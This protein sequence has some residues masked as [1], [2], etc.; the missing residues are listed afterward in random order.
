MDDLLKYIPRER[1]G[2]VVLWDPSDPDWVL[3]LNLL[4]APTFRERLRKFANV[5]SILASLFENGW[6]GASDRNAFNIGYGMLCKEQ[7]PTFAHFLKAL[8]SKDYREELTPYID[9]ANVEQFFKQFDD[10]WSKTQRNTS[11]APLTNKADFFS[12]PF[13]REVVGYHSGVDLGAIQN[14]RPIFLCR[15]SEGKLGKD[16]VTAFASLLVAEILSAALERES[17]PSSER[18]DMHWYIDE[19]HTTVRPGENSFED[20]FRETRKYGIFLHALDQTTG[21]RSF[22]DLMKTIIGN[23]D[24][25]AIGKVG[26]E[27]AELLAA[28]LPIDEPNTLIR[29]N[30]HHWYVTTTLDDGTTSDPYF[31]KTFRPPMVL[32]HGK[33]VD[34]QAVTSRTRKNYMHPRR[35]VADFI[36]HTLT[37]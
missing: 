1:A 4:K 28:A 3:C 13:I 8:I 16:L 11:I 26:P 22:H 12:K 29:L 24:T 2:D 9:A 20:I 17:I 25:L 34:V 18:A 14:N 23:V 35:K 19:F 37:T 36:N 27:D 30:A 5:V 6:G 31:M 21:G 10:E 33:R 7:S 32:P 15:F